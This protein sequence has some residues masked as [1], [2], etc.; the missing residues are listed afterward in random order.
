MNTNRWAPVLAGV[1][2]V[3]VALVTASVLL[4]LAGGATLA[5]AVRDAFAGWM[6]SLRP[7][8]KHERRVA[9]AVETAVRRRMQ[10]PEVTP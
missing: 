2:L 8:S 10:V 9:N 7:A 4:A 6:D 3:V 1:G 5:L